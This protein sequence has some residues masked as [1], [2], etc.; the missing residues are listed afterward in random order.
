MNLWPVEHFF[1]HFLAGSALISTD[2]AKKWGEKCSTGQRFIFTELTSYKIHT[3]V[4]FRLYSQQ[5]RS[6]LEF[7][8]SIL[9]SRLKGHKQ[10]EDRFEI[11]FRQDLTSDI[12]TLWPVNDVAEGSTHECFLE[13]LHIWF[14]IPA[15]I[16]L[17]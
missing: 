9:T 6:K 15:I 12:L 11:A 1:P 17:W 3:L 14:E 13:Q 5:K 7:V 4:F 8:A 10:L 16:A 2:P